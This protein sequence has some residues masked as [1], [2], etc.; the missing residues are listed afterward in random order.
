MRYHKAKP[1]SPIEAQFIIAHS[2]TSENECVAIEFFGK[3][4]DV[5]KLTEAELDAFVAELL[6]ER[7]VAVSAG[8]LAPH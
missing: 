6:Q 2:T 3:W 4:F 8:L 7:E 5:R 1:V